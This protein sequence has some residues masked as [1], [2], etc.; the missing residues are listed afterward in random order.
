MQFKISESLKEG[1]T[2]DRLFDSYEQAMK[3]Y[4][5]VLIGGTRYMEV[6]YQCSR[7]WTP[8][9]EIAQWT[10]DDEGNEI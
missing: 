10:A 7:G 3:E 4:N 5:R 1:F 6:R 9:E 2:D 8:W